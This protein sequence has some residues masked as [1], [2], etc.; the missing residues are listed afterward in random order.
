M[1][2]ENKSEIVIQH[3]VDPSYLENTLTKDITALEAIF[4]LVDNAIDAAR[5]R[6]LRKRGNTLDQYGLPAQYNEGKISIRIGRES[7]SFLDNCSGIDE[8]ELTKHAFVI[9]AMSHHPYGIGRFGIG[10]KRA[11]IRLGTQYALSTDT[12][13]F[14]AKIRFNSSQLKNT[15]GSLLATR[16]DSTGHN[17]T[18]IHVAGLRDGVLHEFSTIPK[19]HNLS[20]NLSRR[21]G[22]ILEKGFKIFLNGNPIRGFGPK[23]RS[24]GPVEPQTDNFP[25]TEGVRVFIDA[26][27]HSEYRLT[28][29][30][31]Y[32]RTKNNS[33]TDQYGWYFVCNDRIVEVATHEIS[34]GWTSRWHQEYYGFVG[35]V[36]FVASD[37]ENLPW[38]TK[39]STIDPNSSAFRAIADRLQQFAEK[40]K[41]ANKNAKG[42]VIVTTLPATPPNTTTTNSPSSTS[43]SSGAHSTQPADVNKK[44][45]TSATTMPSEKAIEDDPA[46]HHNEN[47]KTLLPPLNTGHQDIKIRALLLEASQL[48]ITKCYAAA[49]LFRSLVERALF[50]HLKYTKSY[51]LV[52]EMLFQ[53]KA[54]DGNPIKEK[55]KGTT[56]PS[57]SQAL[58]WLSK[59]D[60]YFPEDKRR[61]CIFARNKLNGHL[62]ELNGIVHEG[63]LTSS[64]KLIIIRNDTM[65]LLLFLLRCSPV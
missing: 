55:Q 30:K 60:I 51:G 31:E 50:E 25:A 28:K 53:E 65:P 26:G 5:N 49:M 62:K 12:G 13:E 36:R 7:I 37:A 56:R 52:L 10:L 39:K 1:E 41:T 3:G 46:F 61:D 21:Y 33:L 34:L 4:E 17:K 43:V 63:D 44:S 35:W 16:E 19:L 38:D 45:V 11:L 18:L 6:A 40:Y 59:N 48:E 22:I 2:N 42:P 9:G 29:E 15:D 64:G 27:M 54:E 20:K 47:W 57:L 14:S 58:A 32:D 8:I 23:I 24:K